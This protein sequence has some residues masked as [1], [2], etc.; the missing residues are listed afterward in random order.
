M[1]IMAS[2][3]AG[4]W[5]VPPLDDLADQ[6]PPARI[7]GSGSYTV[8]I[9]SAGTGFSAAA[10]LALT[11]WRGDRIED[12]QGFLVHLRDRE[13]HA[14]WSLAPRT[15]PAAPGSHGA[16]WRPGVFE[17]TRIEAGIVAQLQVCVIPGESAELRSLHVRNLSGRRRRLD[18]TTC[19]EVVLNDAVAHAA[20]PVFSKLFLQTESVPAVPAILVR[21]RPRAQ[22]ERYPW[23]IHALIGDGRGD[24]VEFETDRARFLGRGPARGLA[25]ALTTG[26]PLEGTSGN[27]LDPVAS[28]RVVLTLEAGEE[29]KVTFLL[30]VAPDRAGALNLAARLA[31]DRAIQESFAQAEA[32]AAVE[33]AG[34]GLSL[35]QA[36]YWQALA[37]AMLYGHPAL[38]AAS[39]ILDQ[40]RGDPEQLARH[41]LSGRRMLAV[42]HAEQPAGAAHVA[43]LSRAHRY[44]QRL[45][46]P[47]DLVVLTGDASTAPQLSP[48]AGE[49][50]PIVLPHGDLF[51]QERHLLDTM[52][53]LVVT[54]S[55]PDLTASARGPVA[56]PDPST[57]QGNA[58]RP[59][60]P[61]ACSAEPLRFCNGYGGFS[62]DGREYV[63]RLS[64]DE[65]GN[66]RHPPLPWIN[67]IANEGF[68]TLVS[69]SGAGCTWRGNSR[70]H[71]LTP[72]FNDPVL[73]PHGEALY[74]RDDRTGAFWSP[75]PGP[76]PAAAGYEMRHGF[77]FS[78]CLVDCAD[79]VQETTLF[80]PRQDPV[81]LAVIRLT[82]R[83][84]RERRLSLFACSQLVLAAPETASSCCIV[85]ANDEDPGT[86]LARNH[87]AGELAGGV[88]FAA[89]VAPERTREI[90]V[91]GDRATFLGRGGHPARPA[92]LRRGGNLDGRTG[93]GLD[94][95]FVQ[96]VVLDLPPDATTEVVFLLGET[97]GAEQVHDLLARLRGPGA[98]A[99]ELAEVQ[100]FWRRLSA[101][102]IETPSAALDLLVN[103]WLTYQT[104]SCRLWGRSAFYQS[105]GA[106]GYRDQLQDAGALVHLWPELTRAQILLH[107]AHQFREGDVLHWWHPPRARG[108]R[109]RFADDL[110]WLPYLAAGYVQT[111]G[112][113]AILD[114]SVPFLD[115]APLAPGQDEAFL[116]PV[117]SGTAADLYEHCCR[118]LDRSLTAGAHG[119]PLF[120]TGDWNDGMNR[121]GREGRGESVWLGFF[122]HATLGDFLPFCEERGDRERA[123]RYRAYRAELGAALNDAGWDGA[124]YR[125]GYYD[126]GTPLGS[127]TS[128]ECRID[129]LAQA[130]AVLSGVAPPERAAQAMAAVQ[131]HLISEEEGLIRLLTPPFDRTPHDPGYIKGYLPGIRENGGQYT[132]AALWVVRALAVLG[133]NDRVAALLDLLNPIHHASTAEQ[134]AVYRVEPY[135][136]AA[137]VYGT[138]PHVGRGG[139]TWYTGAAGWMIR[140]AL[141][142]LLG[143]RLEGGDTLVL[144]P[145][146][147]DDWP[148]FTLR[149]TLPDQRT[150]YVIHAANPRGAAQAVQGATVDGRPAPAAA[151][152]CRIPL[153]KDGQEHRVELVL[154]PGRSGAHGGEAGRQA[155]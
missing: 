123:R 69:E 135:V 148:E 25:R 106:F 20:H 146:I 108:L 87:A 5:P 88:A 141:E 76:A 61:A 147:P 36:E 89:V 95:C 139:W 74:V 9:S 63:I 79:L 81:R 116:Q 77:G 47:I 1:T 64:L 35:R 133:R 24:G 15:V 28:L 97:D 37:G 39:Q 78:R 117:D 68:G 14:V 43:A 49:V 29:A 82:N 19:A 84:G 129:A 7:L 55:L 48:A 23:L 149:Y 50:P 71:R 46:L 85:T 126:D 143:F 122:L 100:A 154:G 128:D 151:D 107:A 113:R 140:V 62:A 51:P 44:W 52:A 8:L 132:H 91:S 142:S 42:L 138:P 65:E 60:A 57:R 120:G 32:Q 118:A 125:R 94:P 137:D 150:R 3:P 114:E 34:L 134:V 67:V 86:I 56:V 93:A 4:A 11:D 58:A 54:G 27:V 73:D 99:R 112:D 127:S 110:L 102:E 59:A 16:R 83:S 31:G 72:W 155:G 40:A 2:P 38:R 96:Q 10:G 70:Q 80:V 17:I 121:V 105:G 30:G 124:W 90:H 92:A 115:A 26:A 13:Q 104:L 153:Q 18:L 33:L 103:G 75:L 119:L 109:T 22:G 6:A 131:E 12:R 144:A 111:T 136:I 21:R 101:L 98:V 130:W 45:G 66:L 53:R 145:C 41:G 152:G